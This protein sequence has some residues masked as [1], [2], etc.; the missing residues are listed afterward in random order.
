MAT[1]I[2]QPALRVNRPYPW[3]C[4][5]SSRPPSASDRDPYILT[6]VNLSSPTSTWSFIPDPS[7]S[8]QSPSWSP[9]RRD[10]IAPYRLIRTPPHFRFPGIQIWLCLQ[11]V[12]S[13]PL[14]LVGNLP[15]PNIDHLHLLSPVLHTPCQIL[16]VPQGPLILLPHPLHILPRTL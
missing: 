11:K 14:Q 8:P 7:S 4:L 5:S 15:I 3:S 2:S 10:I 16:D 12:Q 1:T 13:C 9:I 6:I